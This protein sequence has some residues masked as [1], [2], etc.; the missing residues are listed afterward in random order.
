[1]LY[2]I[3]AVLLVILLKSFG[4]KQTLKVIGWGLVGLVALGLV[5]AVIGSLGWWVLALG[6]VVWGIEML[7]T[8]AVAAGV[9]KARE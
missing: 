8:D 9:R 2:T 6:L 3:I 4:G 1:M 7:I 5:V